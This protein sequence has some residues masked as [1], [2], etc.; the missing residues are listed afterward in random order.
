MLGRNGRDCTISLPSAVLPIPIAASAEWTR[1]PAGRTVVHRTTS[2]IGAAMPTRSTPAG[3]ADNAGRV[4]V[5]ERRDRHG[6]GSRHAH[7]AEADGENRSSNNPFH[8]PVSLL[9]KLPRISIAAPAN[10]AT[11]PITPVMVMPVVAPA[12]MAMVVPAPMS[13]VVPAPMVT[14]M[15]VHLLRFEPS[16]VV[17]RGQ[18][19]VNIWRSLRAPAFSKR[20]RSQQRGLRACSEQA[21]AYGKPSCDIQYGPAF[22]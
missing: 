19:A 4:R 21:R 8:R 12:P 15:P 11:L 9:L 7:L 22:H 17:T 2:T 5:V 10:I 16:D 3:D 13:A 1:V 6:P 20:L 18:R 14:A